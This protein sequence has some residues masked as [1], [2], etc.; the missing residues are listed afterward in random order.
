MAAASSTAPA[1]AARPGVSMSRPLQILSLVRAAG[2]WLSLTAVIAISVRIATA[3]VAR[4]SF[5]LA[6]GSH[7]LHPAWLIGPL[8]APGGRLKLDA[9]VLL[10]CVLAGAW[11]MTLLC[12][13]ALPRWAVPAAI[14][15]TTLTFTLAPPLLSRDVFNYIAYGRLQVHGINPYV[16]GPAVLS[17]DPV[18][19][20]TGHMW[21]H[22]PSAYG[23]LFTL[24]SAAL[25]PFGTVVSLWAL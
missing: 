4:T 25:A 8:P 3:G 22:A 24:I 9:F 7:G 23:T 15:V 5:L 14:V 21:K 13:A 19:P 1:H 2:G 11:L 17:H 20:F 16:H 18:Y 10:I 6:G 12:A